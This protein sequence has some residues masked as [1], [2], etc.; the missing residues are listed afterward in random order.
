MVIIKIHFGHY[1]G[2]IDSTAHGTKFPRI[3]CTTAARRCACYIFV[4]FEFD[5]SIFYLYLVILVSVFVSMMV[6][7]VFFNVLS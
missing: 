6:F 2:K 7:A 1:V 5:I 3:F 4:Y